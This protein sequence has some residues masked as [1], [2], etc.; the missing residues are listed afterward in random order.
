MTKT[1]MKQQA[2]DHILD[3]V[4]V[5]LGYWHEQLP[6]RGVEI[7]EELH[8]EFRAIMQ[9]QADRVAKLFGYERAWSS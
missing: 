1:E 2:Q 5:A 9:V 4:S 3:A 8:D 7:P 6:A